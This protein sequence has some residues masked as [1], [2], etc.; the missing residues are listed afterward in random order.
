MLD[1]NALRYRDLGPIDCSTSIN[2]DKLKGKTVLVTGGSSGLGFAYVKAYSEAGATVINAD[3]KD[4]ANDVK[5]SGVHYTNC[6]VRSWA[7]QKKAFQLAASKSASGL[8]DI[9]VANAGISGNDHFLMGLDAADVQEPDM[10]IVNIDLIGAMYTIRL[11][12]NNFILHPETGSTNKCLIIKA[13]LA[14]YVD[15][16]PSYGSAKFGLRA[17]M[18]ALR[19]KDYCRVN[20]VAPWFI[21]TPIMTDEVAG[22]LGAQLK[23]QDSDFAHV[24]D[25]V[26]C[27]LRISTDESI[28]G[29]AFGII[30][31]QHAKEGY[32]DLQQDEFKKDDAVMRHLQAA[33]LQVSHRK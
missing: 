1:E 25:S 20:L 32:I 2:L 13:S 28:H 24:E 33:V 5:L 22:V 10:R 15:T 12:L 14:A 16:L 3:I 11:A 7:D 27:V 21:H 31:R 18:R 29:R 8:I 4:I 23:K 9:V 26:H 17:V 30:P 19:N 6:D